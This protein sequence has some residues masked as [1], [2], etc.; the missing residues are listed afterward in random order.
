ME[1]PSKI[2]LRLFQRK[3]PWRGPSKHSLKKK[4]G[5]YL[6]HDYLTWLFK[7]VKMSQCRDHHKA[8][9]FHNGAK[10]L[11]NSHS[12]FDKDKSREVPFH[13][14]TSSYSYFE[15]I[16]IFAPIQQE[17]KHDQEKIWAEQKWKV[18]WQS[19]AMF[20]LL[21]FKA[22]FKFAVKWSRFLET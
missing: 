16:W 3:L 17:A 13:G 14:I 12:K 18:C 1:E 2:S 15:V 6:L 11:M 19:P 10:I 22:K 4:S 9:A 7:S 20:C 21:H 5:L 8:E